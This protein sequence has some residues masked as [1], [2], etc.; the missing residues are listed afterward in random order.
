MS[1]QTQQSTPHHAHNTKL[2][3][4]KHQTTT[5]ESVLRSAVE[6]YRGNCF[7]QKSECTTKINAVSTKAA[8]N[9][10]PEQLL[11]IIIDETICFKVYSTGIL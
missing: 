9:T 6:I 8:Y 1:F 5:T 3:F 11:A 4:Y 2:S 10:L 7:F